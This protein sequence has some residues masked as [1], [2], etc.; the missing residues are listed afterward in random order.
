M[1]VV[2]LTAYVDIIQEKNRRHGVISYLPAAS[3][4]MYASSSLAASAPLN[5]LDALGLWL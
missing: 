5:L 4:F 3:H 2:S 1:A